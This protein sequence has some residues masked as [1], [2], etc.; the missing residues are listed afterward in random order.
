MRRFIATVLL[1]G[2]IVGGAWL[3][4]HHEQIKSLEDAWNLL[5]KSIFSESSSV[6]TE[7]QNL[8][9]L[10]STPIPTQLAKW[11]IPNPSG[12]T[13]RVATFNLQAMGSSK[14]EDESTVRYLTD[15]IRSFDV[16]AIQE[17]EG[18]DPA[19]LQ[20]FIHRINNNRFRYAF[21][22]S[23]LLGGNR[24]EQSAFIFNQ[25]TVRL[26]DSF[27]YSVSDPDQILDRQPFVGW[28]RTARPRPDQAFTFSLVN[29][30]FSRNRSQD[31]L[32]YL[33]QLFRAVRKD[34][35][36]EDDVMILGDF[37]SG[38]RALSAISQQRGLTWVV[39]NKPTNT[40]G[41][42][43]LDNLLYDSLATTEFTGQFGAF[44]FLR[45]FNLSL[46]EA[47]KISDH[48]PVWAEFSVF[49]GASPGESQAACSTRDTS[50]YSR[51]HKRVHDLIAIT[52]LAWA[53]DALP[54][55]LRG[56]AQEVGRIKEA[57]RRR[58]GN[59]L[60]DWPIRHCK[61]KV[62]PVKTQ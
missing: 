4:Y 46:E 47:M 2:V 40:M 53:M 29:V 6:G 10:T 5:T 30:R 57:L 11:P 31:E 3:L 7:S 54:S 56:H 33:P 60:S 26:D 22:L 42:A 27:T 16:V 20:R 9:G 50:T 13:I 24:N 32:A 58:S 36:G 21:T 49:E 55:A 19:V 48:L 59:R 38:G 23:P 39:N 61:S 41:T 18:G 52:L 51:S 45:E 14:F 1:A 43:Q 62:T 8:N 44:D 35:R 28:F 37:Q 25:D 34:G 15:I 12:E 17:I